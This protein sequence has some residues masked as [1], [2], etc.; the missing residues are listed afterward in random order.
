MQAVTQKNR[1]ERLVEW[2]NKLIRSAR[3]FF[4][5][6]VSYI[7]IT[8][9]AV[10]FVTAHKEVHGAVAFVAI[11]AVILLVC[12]DILP[13]LLPFLLVC[14]FTT[15]CYNSMATFIKFIPF[16]PLVVVCVVF[17]FVVYPKKYYTGESMYGIG[18]VSVAL[19]LGGVGNYSFMQ[20]AT[21]AFYWLGLGVGMLLAYYVM[22]A[23]Y[24]GRRNYD[25]K[26]RFAVIMSLMGL[27][28]VYIIG[29]GYV[30]PRIGFPNYPYAVGFSRNNICTMLMFAMPFPLYLVKRHQL[31]ALGSVI[32]FGALCATTSRGGLLFGAVE[33]GACAL[34]WMFLDKRN[35][36]VRIGV[37]MIAVGAVLVCFGMVIADVVVNRLLGEDTIEGSDRYVMFIQG[38]HRFAKSPLV[39]SGILDDSI[40][41]GQYR[42][43]GT[44]PWYH[45]FIP[46]VIGGMGLIGVLAYGYQTWLRASLA[47]RKASRWS[48][49]LGIS[50]LGIFLMSQ[51]NPGEF[52][53]VPFQTLAV[54]L[55]LMQEIRLEEEIL[56]LKSK[57][58]TPKNLL[59][60]LEE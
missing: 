46:Q 32:F 5:S 19:L 37:C 13:T 39:G 23:E 58:N 48:L 43:S 55:T 41:Y 47:L 29:L 4:N 50:Y 2:V 9:A 10:I 16:A 33:F 24:A 45:M 36:K 59:T 28:C 26:E 1:T 44:M 6:Y 34:Y 52:C 14:T 8:L 20:Y 51:V 12:D 11:L 15:N 60:T 57:G 3:R 53:P 49:V 30:R 21:G 31:A 40:V 25:L 18:A 56:P 7:A 27:L 38:M 42:K 22:K 54:L 35:I 17:H